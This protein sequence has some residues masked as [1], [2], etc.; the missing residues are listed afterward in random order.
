M[1]DFTSGVAERFV[2]GAAVALLRLLLCTWVD[3]AGVLAAPAGW[4]RTTP[5][6]VSVPELFCLTVDSVLLPVLS[7][8]TALLVSVRVLTADDPRVL[9]PAVVVRRPLLTAVLS[10]VRTADLVS[11]LAAA[12][13]LLFTSRRP[14][15]VLL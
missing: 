6:F 8:L 10:E 7:P 3:R 1:A 5:A 4:R 12:E 15:L 14:P 2:A 11:F 9:V 13:P